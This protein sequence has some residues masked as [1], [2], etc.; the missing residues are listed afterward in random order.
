MFCLWI[1]N[2][3]YTKL[4]MN[5]LLEHLVIFTYKIYVG[6]IYYYMDERRTRERRRSIHLFKVHHSMTKTN[7]LI[8]G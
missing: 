6:S 8:F 1:K 2:D 4:G 7:I 5:E 3:K